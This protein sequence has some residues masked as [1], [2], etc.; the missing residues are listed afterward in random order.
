[1]HISINS[2]VEVSLK[3]RGAA[4][5]NKDISDFVSFGLQVISMHKE[6]EKEMLFRQNGGYLLVFF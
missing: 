2:T 1:M 4:I 5:K 6:K 3:V